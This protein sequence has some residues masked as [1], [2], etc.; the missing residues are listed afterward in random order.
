MRRGFKAEAERIAGRIRDEMN[1]PADT[2][3][4]PHDIATHLGIEILR[5]D[6]LVEREELE[7]LA[8]IQPD[9]WSAAT[10]RKPSGELVVVVNPLSSLGRTR[11]DLAHELAHV[12]LAHTTGKVEHV[13]PVAFLTCDSLQEEE[14]NWLAGCLLL[15]RPILLA[16]AREGLS[17]ERLAADCD[18]SVQMARFRL[19]A[20]GVLI[21]VGHERRRGSNV[22]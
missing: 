17:P 4:D 19:N 5:A 22:G 12:L 16:A 6:L 20:S 8:K 7:K 18:V 14:A 21:Q 13:G 3:L 10:F 15:P 1:R 11:S 2:A 9:A